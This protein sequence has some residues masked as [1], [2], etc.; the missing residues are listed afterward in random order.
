MI[1]PFD[2][3]TRN[4]LID[5]YEKHLMK[6]CDDNWSK[7]DEEVMEEVELEFYERYGMQVI[8]F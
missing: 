4:E 6:A 8:P 3:M 2:T 1:E 7:V 5:F